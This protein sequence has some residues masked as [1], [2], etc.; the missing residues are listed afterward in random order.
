MS[1]SVMKLSNPVKRA[2]WFLVL[3]TGGRRT[4]MAKAEWAHI[5]FDRKKKGDKKPSM[6]VWLFPDENTKGDN[7]YTI[8]LSPFVVKFLT[9]W[10]KYV[11]SEYAVKPQVFHIF[12]STKTKEGHLKAPRNPLHTPDC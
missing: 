5:D 10:R 9:E 12:P 4:Q 1:I 6:P 11:E 7:G 2:Y 3:M 8:A